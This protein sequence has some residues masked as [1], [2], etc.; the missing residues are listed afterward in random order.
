MFAQRGLRHAGAEGC[1][2]P[3]QASCESVSGSFAMFNGHA[4]QHTQIGSTIPTVNDSE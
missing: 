2:Y 3:P 4:A 1:L